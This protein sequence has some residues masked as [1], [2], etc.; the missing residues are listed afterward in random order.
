MRV[1]FLLRET[2]GV[3]HVDLLMCHSIVCIVLQTHV[4]PSFC[5]VI[6]ALCVR[7]YFEKGKM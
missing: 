1:K 2:T 3:F 4:I 6:D 7:V 5:H